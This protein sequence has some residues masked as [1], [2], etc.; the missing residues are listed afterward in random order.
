[1]E[2]INKWKPDWYC[3]QQVIAFLYIQNWLIHFFSGNES[4]KW[5]GCHV[6]VCCI[7]FNGTSC[8]VRYCCWRNGVQR[9]MHL[10][11]LRILVM[12]I[13]WASNVPWF[14]SHSEFLSVLTLLVGWQERHLVCKNQCNICPKYAVLKKWRNKLGGGNQLTQ[15]CLENGHK[16]GGGDD[17]VWVRHSAYLCQHVHLLH[18]CMLNIML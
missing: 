16:N 6:F 11:S 17:G 9:A 14:G 10:P 5:A 3:W 8:S 13:I 1:M 18:R 4:M 7:L 12:D 15:S 2:K